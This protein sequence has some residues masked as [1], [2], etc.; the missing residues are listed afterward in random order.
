MDTNRINILYVI[1][2]L[3]SG[4]K[5]RQFVEILKGLDKDKFRIGIITFNKN[6]FYT[7]K[8]K[9]LSEYFVELEKKSNKFKPFFTI[10]ACF[11]DFKPDIVHSWD[12][13][14]SLFVYF[15]VKFYS[16]IFVNGSIRDSGIE[17][18]WQFYAK[19]WML[20]AANVAL[21]NS[22]AG[23][24]SYGVEGEVIYNAIDLGRFGHS[25]FRNEFNIIKVA[26]FSDYKNHQMFVDASIELVKEK[27][28]DNVYLAGN[29]EYFNK[30]KSLVEKQ[31]EEVSAKFHFLGAISNVETYLEKC[32]IGLLCSTVKYSEGVSNSVLE[33]MA[34][35]L[36]PIATNIGATSEIIQDGEN[37]FL[38]APDSFKEIVNKV[39]LIKNNPEM[40]V[41]MVANAM[42][43][44]ELKFNYNKNMQKINHLYDKVLRKK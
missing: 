25:K 37:G 30:Y 16:A 12:Y 14:S 10:W 42:K 7:E 41:K 8:A 43:T 27:F 3:F 40:S 32:T 21:G 19:K 15:P 31:K 6:L 35:G 23:L 44:I 26:N 34:A 29:G 39:K 2:G 11:K 5:E 20:K 18:G 13:L 33:Y 38:V 24:S 17:K 1:D 28:V 9:S 4:G 22:K 36:I